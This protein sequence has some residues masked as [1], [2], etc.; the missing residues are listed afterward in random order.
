MS[1]ARA[2]GTSGHERPVDV[3]A[4]GPALSMFWPIAEG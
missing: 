4:R 2:G 3:Q 1:P